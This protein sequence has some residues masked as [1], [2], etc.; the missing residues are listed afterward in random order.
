MNGVISVVEA[1]DDFTSET[2][3]SALRQFAKDKK[4]GKLGKVMMPLRAALTG[5]DK[6]PSLFHSME[7]LGKE[8]SVKRITLASE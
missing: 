5:T 8:E 7:A 4:D 6:S 1:I 3:E 2:I